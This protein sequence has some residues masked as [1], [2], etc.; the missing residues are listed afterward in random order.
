MMMMMMMKT[1]ELVSQKTRKSVQAEWLRFEK[2][3]EL[4]WATQ[5]CQ[6]AV[7]W[8]LDSRSIYIYMYI[9]LYTS[10][11]L[12]LRTTSID[13]KTFIMMIKIGISQHSP[14]R[15]AFFR[16]CRH[17]RHALCRAA[18]TIAASGSTGGAGR[19]LAGTIRIIVDI[20]IYQPLMVNISQNGVKNSKSGT[21][22]AKLWSSV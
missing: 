2:P 3:N 13:Y 19:C 15:L 18:P 17:Q 14:P 8:V 7:F 10:T 4:Q 20:P 21:T 5:N 11:V 6:W 1:K 22:N 12:L 9:Y 16:H